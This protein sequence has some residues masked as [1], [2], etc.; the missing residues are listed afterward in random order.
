MPLSA[1]RS[2]DLYFIYLSTP[3]S[4][5]EKNQMLLGFQKWE[6][7]EKQSRVESNE[8]RGERREGRGQRESDV[9]PPQNIGTSFF[10]FFFTDA[11]D[12]G[13]TKNSGWPHRR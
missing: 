11:L 6:L 7:R 3:S 1:M 10:F 8:R 5:E 9:T 4:I 2:S 12:E 13:K